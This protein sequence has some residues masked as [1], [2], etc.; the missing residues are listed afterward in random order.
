MKILNIN[1]VYNGFL[2]ILKLEI[3]TSKGNTI[4]REVMSRG[5][6]ERTDDSVA[7]L[8][9][10]TNKQR[11]IFVK[12]FRSGL[13]NQDDKYLMEVVAGTLDRGEDPKE[14]MIREI[15]EETGYKVELRGPGV[16][17]GGHARPDG[18]PLRQN[19]R[20]AHPLQLP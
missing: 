11:Y 18:L 8:I 20:A 15:K 1:R 4:T 2:S 10:D 14:C 17:A 13:I 6:D 5:N 3:E 16:P 19:H 12:Q 7:S 9:Y